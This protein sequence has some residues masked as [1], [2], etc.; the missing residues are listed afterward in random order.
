MRIPK[1][2]FAPLAVALLC[3][4]SAVRAEAQAV[5]SI[6]VFTFPFS[7]ALTPADYPCLEEVILLDGTLHAVERLTLDA[8][9][10]RHRAV[11]FNV[12]GD[13]SGL[14]LT[15]GTVYQVSGPG[16]NVF[17]DGDL[18][19]P[20]RERTF[21]D[22]INVVGPGDATNLR[23]RTGFHLT[24]NSNGELVASTT[25]DSVECR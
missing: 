7:F 2:I 12:Q 4:G 8:S 3:L 25:V 23:V 15:S 16:H 11:L 18:T 13:L 22:V 10:G 14:G 6:E 9:G 5:T 24:F 21:Y 17:N 20:V 1:S 19:P